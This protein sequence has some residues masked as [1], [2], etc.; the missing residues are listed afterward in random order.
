MKNIVISKLTNHK[1]HFLSYFRCCVKLVLGHGA[2]YL[3]VNRFV[4]T[5]GHQ[6]DTCHLW[7]ISRSWG[8]SIFP[9]GMTSCEEIWMS[10]SKLFRSRIKMIRNYVKSSRNDDLNSLL[11]SRPHRI[12]K[13]DISYWHVCMYVRQLRVRVKFTSKGTFASSCD[14]RIRFWPASNIF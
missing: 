8:F 4:T 6:N 10:F 7:Q 1:E 5:N 3:S 13:W 12:E 2:W 9:V 11:N 14:K